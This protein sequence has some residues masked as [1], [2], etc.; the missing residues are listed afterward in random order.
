MDMSPRAPE[1]VVYGLDGIHLGPNPMSRDS[2]GAPRS[3]G[4]SRWR[5]TAE[6]GDELSTIAGCA[7]GAVL[8]AVVVMSLQIADPFDAAV[9]VIGIAIVGVYLGHRAWA[10]VPDSRVPSDH[11]LRSVSRLRTTLADVATALTIALLYVSHAGP[12]D[13]PIGMPDNALSGT[14]AMIVLGLLAATTVEVAFTVATKVRD[15]KPGDAAG[16]RP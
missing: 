13:D 4:T 7:L 11:V 8:G 15:R 5:R 9:A 3:E 12:A 6:L 14:A 16:L 10:R 1:D 2:V